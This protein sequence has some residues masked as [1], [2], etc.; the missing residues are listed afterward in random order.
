MNKILFHINKNRLLYVLLI[1]FITFLAKGIS[2][3]TAI[4]DSLEFIKEIV[5]GFVIL[6]FS[7]HS[8]FLDKDL[9][10][11]NEKLINSINNLN[12]AKKNGDIKEVNY[13]TNEKNEIESLIGWKNSKRENYNP[14]LFGFIYGALAIVT[15]MMK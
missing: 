14:I 5:L 8:F 4:V 6:D 13:Y 15:Y 9:K 7:I 12:E 10:E 2:K 11:L 1:C 3:K